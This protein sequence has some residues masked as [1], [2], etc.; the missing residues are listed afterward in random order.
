MRIPAGI[1]RKRFVVRGV[2]PDDIEWRGMRLEIHDWTYDITRVLT[3]ASVE[4]RVNAKLLTRCETKFGIC[5]H[6][7]DGEASAVRLRVKAE[8]DNFG[9][10]EGILYKSVNCTQSR[11]LE[12]C[13]P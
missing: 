3:P 11:K 10:T 2:I 1:N 4:T 6:I 8:L 5:G 7:P 12:R 9:Y 13:I